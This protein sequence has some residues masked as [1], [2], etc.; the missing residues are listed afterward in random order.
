MSLDIRPVV[1]SLL[2]NRTGAVL[3]AFQIAIALAVLVNA[4]FIVQQRIEKTNRPTLLDDQ[5]LFGVAVG[6]FTD[7]FNYDASLREDLDYLRSL[8]GVVSAS[9]SNS[10]PLG[11]SG[12]ATTVWTQPDN[13]GNRAQ[14][15]YFSMDEQGLKT[16][17]VRLIA[18]R[19]FRVNEIL[20]PLTA[21]NSTDF[22]PQLI[23][24]Q[25]VAEKL[26]P[27][28]N[29]LGKTVYDLRG[30]PA[31]ITGIIDNMTGTAYWGNEALDH[32]AIMPQLPRLYG[33]DYLVRTE[34]GRRDA[35]MRTV[36]EHLSTSN[37]DRVIKFVRSV[38]LF[39]KL[40]Y[41]D[42]RNMEVFLI[43]VTVLLLAIASL[44]IFGLATFNVSARTK[45]IGTR[46]AVGAR[47]VDIVRYFMVENGLI[48]TAGIAVGC[49][50]ALAIGYWLSLQYQLPR[51]DLYYLVGGVLALWLI[52]QAAAWQPARRAAAVSPSVATRTV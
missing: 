39:K 32:V 19:A 44:G 40:L 35:I 14:I 30:R 17:G 16:L 15:N 23:V 2:R 33:F 43:T 36:E 52:G 21:Q 51:L 9:V 20:P 38:E 11:I 10:I 13:K 7:R 18:G 29:A 42:D 28:E 26:F 25:V 12:S 6:E 46:R 45:Q 8:P 31:T 34:P 41:R 49:A 48:T 22:V 4:V 24:T 47:R 5:N 1:S 37:P 50:L 27:H 3:V